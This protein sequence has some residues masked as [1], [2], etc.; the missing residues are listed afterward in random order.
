MSPQKIGQIVPFEARAHMSKKMQMSLLKPWRGWTNMKGYRVVG[1]WCTWLQYLHIWVTCCNLMSL[2]CS[3]KEA[4]WKG[5]FFFGGGGVHLH[6]GEPCLWIRGW[7]C[8]ALQFYFYNCVKLSSSPGKSVTLYPPEFPH[9][10][11]WVSAS[12]TVCL[13]SFTLSWAGHSTTQNPQM[14]RRLSGKT[15][16]GQKI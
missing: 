8:H 7:M 5:G 12:L 1:V 15:E 4:W 2:N 10:Q 16:S 6:W 9:R 11:G 13:S 14:G 3:S